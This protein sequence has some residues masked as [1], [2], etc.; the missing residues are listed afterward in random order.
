MPLGLPS[1]LSS[2][3]GNH[4]YKMRCAVP[5]REALSSLLCP[6]TSLC[7]HKGAGG[8]GP[9]AFGTPYLIVCRHLANCDLVLAEAGEDALVGVAC[10]GHLGPGWMDLSKDPAIVHLQFQ[11][12]HRQAH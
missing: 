8:A 7:Q 11:A 4:G 12:A 3:M 1:P 10:R 2:G 9:T 5:T 6:R